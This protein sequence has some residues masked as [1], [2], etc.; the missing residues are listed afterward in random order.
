LSCSATEKSHN[1]DRQKL[2]EKEKVIEALNKCV[3][4]KNKVI[5]NLERSLTRHSLVNSKFELLEVTNE[6]KL[7]KTKS[8]NSWIVNLK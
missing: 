2:I 6:A 4:D 1:L 5:A 3:D 8:S 7:L